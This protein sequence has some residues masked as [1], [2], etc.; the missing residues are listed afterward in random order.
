MNARKCVAK[1]FMD[2]NKSCTVN[3]S[4]NA[5]FPCEQ[6]VEINQRMGYRYLVTLPLCMCFIRYRFGSINTTIPPSIPSFSLLFT[7]LLNPISV[8]S[9]S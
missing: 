4:N 2:I 1:Q 3:W 8:F 6:N 9:A 5:T 7:S